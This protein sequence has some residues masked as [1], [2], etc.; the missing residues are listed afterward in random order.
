MYNKCRHLKNPTYFAIGETVVSLVNHPPEIRSGDYMTIVSHRTEKLY[1]VLLSNGEL[2]RWFAQSELKPLDPLPYRDLA[3]GDC[4]VISNTFGHD[5][6]L[7]NGMIVKIAKIISDEVFYDV[8]LIDGNYHRWL[9]DFE[10]AEPIHY[11]CRQ[12]TFY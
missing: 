8:Q 5:T 4:A 7:Q 12:T 9:A 3:V 2:H 6:R 11:T 10:L 1:A